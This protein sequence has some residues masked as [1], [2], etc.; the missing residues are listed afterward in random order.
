MIKSI[1]FD[2]WYEDLKEW[3]KSQLPRE[4]EVTEIE[5]EGPRIVIYSKN[6]EYLLKQDVV[7]SIAKK[8]HKRISIRSDPSIRKDKSEAQKI[9]FNLVGHLAGITDIIFDDITGQVFIEAEKP[10][11]VI[12]PQGETRRKIAMLTGWSPVII[13]APPLKSNI[14]SYTR[15]LQEISLTDRVEFLKRVGLRIHR[16]Y[17][18]RSN[19]RVRVIV[20]G[21]GR[22]V[23]GN[24]FLV[25]TRE[26]NI[27]VDAGARVGAVNP[28][29]IFPSFN[30]PE[31]II[32][33]L[34]AVIVTHAHLDHSGMVPYLFK[35]GYRGPV[36]CTEPT[37]YLMALLQ[38]DYIDLARKEGKLLP[39]SLSDIDR[40]L[41]HTITLNYE[42]VNDIAPDV[43]LTLYNAGHILGSAIV[44]LHI[45]EGLYNFVFA[46]DIKYADTRLL[47][48]AQTNF[49]RVEAVFI[50]STYGAV[51][52]IAPPQ[53]VAER[54]LIN[55][56]IQTFRRGGKVLIPVL[57][58]GRA[59]ELMLVLYY[60]MRIRKELP[61]VPV[62]LAGM[63]QEAVAIHTV[64]PEFLSRRLRDRILHKRDNPFLADFFIHVRDPTHIEEISESNEQAI[65]L[66][67]HSML[68]GGP[69]VEFLKYLG[70][71]SNNSLVFVSYQAPGTLGWSILRGAREVIVY[72]DGIPRKIHLKLEIKHIRGFSGHSPFPELVQFIKDMNSN[73]RK[74][75][76]IHGEE[77]KAV[78]FANFVKERLKIDSYAPYNMETLRF[79]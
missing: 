27:L 32:D 48:R 39:Y 35:Y 34:D 38:R 16:P 33:E 66:A 74:V 64:S 30:I 2:S 63:I 61:E 26:S 58:V 56:I 55:T 15:K 8:L 12:G 71:S 62:Y 19:N 75:I 14:V 59:Q 67:T 52:D 51:R 69:V 22:E 37:K 79:L 31:F 40:A 7:K 47:D 49:P 11:I 54:E 41:L 5:F 76:V 3:I 6:P 60:Y 1:R 77:R 72:E 70:E 43:R 23:G 10:G 42:E 78:Q 29:E 73:I 13:R 18:M 65:I 36:Y 20:L 4:S 21:A 44:H 17:L 57:A 24:A 46:S 50:E 68:Q 25:Q 45:A 28:G 9:I 53:T